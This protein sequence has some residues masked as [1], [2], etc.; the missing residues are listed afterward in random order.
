MFL[1]GLTRVCAASLFPRTFLLC[2][3]MLSALK[4]LRKNPPQPQSSASSPRECTP[5]L[6]PTLVPMHS[7]WPQKPNPGLLV[8][9]QIHGVAFPQCQ[10]PSS[11]SAKWN[12]KP[13][14]WL[15]LS[16]VT[17]GKQK[18][19]W[20][21]IALAFP[22]APNPPCL[23]VLPLLTQRR[24][25]RSASLHTTHAQMLDGSCL[26]VCTRIKA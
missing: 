13:H 2:P 6:V 11:P 14:L 19:K 16:P 21:F 18:A 24:V 10:L 17:Q 15:A 7:L 5:A 12:V 20:L 25:H 3:Q 1:E 22:K 4:E 9:P 26:Q 23:P 8:C